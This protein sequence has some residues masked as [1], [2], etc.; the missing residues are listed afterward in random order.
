KVNDG[1]AQYSHL[2]RTLSTLAFG[3]YDDGS[4]FSSSSDD[5]A[6]VSDVPQQ[7]RKTPRVVPGLRM[8]GASG[9]AAPPALAP[10]PL[11]VGM[12]PPAGAPPAPPAT[13]PSPMSATRMARNEGMG[14]AT[15][16]SSSSRAE[17]GN[18]VVNSMPLAE[19]FVDGRRRG[20]T[21]MPRLTLPAG[22]HTV[23][24]RTS[25]GRRHSET[26]D[27]EAGTTARVI[28]RF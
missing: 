23:E 5:E 18:L 4:A 13:E 11:P 16:A 12:A 25:D 22:R 1:T 19:V 7:Q 17:R 15:R 10:A 3:S 26:V 8:R 6:V 14:S 28:H 2:A 9:Q 21:P 27:L 20:R 24:L